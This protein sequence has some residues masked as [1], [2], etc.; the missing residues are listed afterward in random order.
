MLN[1]KNA[2]KYLLI[3]ASIILVIVLVY[4]V[5]TYNKSNE[6]F[7]QTSPVIFTAGQA[8]TWTVPDG[9]TSVTFTVI[10]CRGGNGYQGSGGYGALVITQLTVTPGEI[11][12]I[13]VGNGQSEPSN[14][15]NGGNGNGT[16]VGGAASYVSKKSDNTIIIVA[17][18]GGASPLMGQPGKSAGISNISTNISSCNTKGGDAL[19]R[20]GGGGGGQ[21]GGNGG[22]DQYLGAYT[23]GESG[24]SYVISTNSSNTIYS[25]DIYGT[26]IIQIEWGTTPS[27]TGKY[28]SIIGIHS[29][30][31]D[32]SLGIQLF[33]TNGQ[34]SW[35]QSKDAAISL[36]GRLPTLN[37]LRGSDWVSTSQPKSGQLF[38]DFSKNST[39]GDSWFPYDN[40][41]NNN[42]EWVSINHS[43]NNGTTHRALYGP[44]DWGIISDYKPFRTKLYISS[45]ALPSNT[46]GQTIVGPSTTSG[47]STGTSNTSGQTIVGPSTTSGQT[48]VGPSTTS[49]QTIVGPSTTSGQ[50]TIQ[51]LHPDG[52]KWRY[53]TTTYKI[54]LNVSDV[55]ASTSTLS[56]IINPELN[57]IVEKITTY[58]GTKITLA[59]IDN[60]GN[61]KYITSKN[62][63]STQQNPSSTQQNPSSTQYQNPSSTQYQNPSST[64]YQNPSS[65]QY[66]NPSSTQAGSV[67][68]FMDSTEP[69]PSSTQQADIINLYGNAG[70]SGNFYTWWNITKN[71]DN[72]YSFNNLSNSINNIIGYNNTNDINIV[73][74]NNINTNTIKWNIIGNTD[75]FSELIS[76]SPTTTSSGSTTGGTA[77]TRNGGGSGGGSGGSGS[78]G[79][80]GSGGGGG[81]GDGSGGSGYKSPQLNLY[82]KDYEGT[83]NVYSP[84]IYYN[85]EHFTAVNQF[86]DTYCKY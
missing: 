16:G 35:Q 86:D 75:S 74:Y 52:R 37:E 23:P 4:I 29:P 55:I 33:D 65:T 77:T 45:S 76:Q 64:Q 8:S 30:P 68:N 71:G 73:K 70:L 62:P 17:G 39:F 85:Q 34:L 46:S 43:T 80:G 12:N 59:F 32:S 25:T 3:I 2:I 27:P 51:I 50:N 9:V 58:Y 20:G 5:V 79:S 81:S 13:Y 67:S 31:C 53:N 61:K 41:D 7:T 38:L 54:T 82:Q 11:Y 10:G 22:T 26:P 47:Q 69:S 48:I 63:S 40:N 1:K 83:S 28:K 66:Q 42:N 18:G 6:K 44:P 56:E 14:I 78:G 84:Y 49:G 57:I 60:S 21:C 15:Y 72:T 24:G 36:G 19:E